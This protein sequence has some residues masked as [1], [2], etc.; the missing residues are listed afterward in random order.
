MLILKEVTE[1]WWNVFLK[2]YL[3]MLHQSTQQLRDFMHPL[4]KMQ[5][6]LFVIV[7]DPRMGYVNFPNSQDKSDLL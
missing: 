2:K 1:T 3:K 5:E 6:P 4:C 7:N